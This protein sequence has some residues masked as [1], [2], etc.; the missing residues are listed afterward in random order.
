MF[1]TIAIINH[2]AFCYLLL[3]LNYPHAVC[4]QLLTQLFHPPQVLSLLARTA[5]LVQKTHVPLLLFNQS[6]CLLAHLYDQSPVKLVWWN[7]GI[8]IL[9][10]LE[11]SNFLGLPIIWNSLPWRMA[12]WVINKGISCKCW[13]FNLILLN[14]RFARLDDEVK[15]ILFASLKLHW[16]FG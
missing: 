3:Y 16:L 4:H 6:Y 2:S 10:T 13:L 8:S 11:F 7:L 5:L 9:H 12:S 14:C 15:F 1:V